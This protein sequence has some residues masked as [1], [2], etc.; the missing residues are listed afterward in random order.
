MNA[1]KTGRRPRFS[2]FLGLVILSGLCVL[3]ARTASRAQIQ[4]E[5]RTRILREGGTVWYDH[6]YDNDVITLQSRL[7][8]EYPALWDWIHSVKLIYLRGGSVSMREVAR[9]PHLEECTIEDRD[10][11]VAEFRQLS[12]LG[13]LKAV[14]LTSSHISADDIHA[15][16]SHSR[17]RFLH[18]NNS[19]IS[20]DECDALKMSYPHVALEIKPQ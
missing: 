19:T 18:V 7:P 3:L 4:A 2:L 15:L 10:I 20:A 14:E 8:R 17:V 16:L 12:R 11:T 13:S 9:L 6:T 5:L 1:T